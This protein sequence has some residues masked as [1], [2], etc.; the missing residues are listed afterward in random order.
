MTRKEK[1]RR[2]ASKNRAY[3]TRRALRL[4]RRE[5]P[6]NVHEARGL[7]I[8]ALIEV[9]HGA[10]R[11]AYRIHG[12]KLL[13]KFP[14]EF[15]YKDGDVEG[16]PE[17]WHDKEGKNHTRMEMKKIR[18]LQAFPIMRKH[19]PPVYYFNARDGVFV[20][21][22]YPRDGRSIYAIHSLVSEMIK[23]F[24][25]V[26]LGDLSPDN[27]RSDPYNLIFIDLGY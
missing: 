20:T 17:V 1:Y 2:T 9:G 13:I 4:I 21:K 15:R 25:G 12:T 22:Y 26:V 16:G 11:M 23:E 3:R 24:C 5:Q 14:V 10:F 18:A 6:K 19:I 8:G 7:G 27:I